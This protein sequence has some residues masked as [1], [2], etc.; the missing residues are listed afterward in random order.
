MASQNDIDVVLKR[1]KQKHAVDPIR[2]L[3]RLV[4]ELQRG[5]AIQPDEAFIL[6]FIRSHLIENDEI[7][8]N[9]L[10]RRG[11]EKG[12]DALY[13]DHAPRQVN[14]IQGKYR[15]QNVGKP[16]KIQ[17]VLQLAH[18]GPLLTGNGDGV[19]KWIESIDV[20]IK[21]KLKE[22]WRLIRHKEYGLNLYYV[23]TGSISRAILR[24]AEDTAQVNGQVK[25]VPI[26][27]REI[28]KII[29]DYIS[30]AAPGIPWLEL[31]I[32]GEA[33]L[34]RHDDKN[35]IDSYVFTMNGKNIGDLL[36]KTGRRLFARNIRGFLGRGSDVNRS[37]G[38]TLQKEPE[39][40]WYF[41]NGVTIICDDAQESGTAGHKRLRVK[42]PQVINGQQTSNMLSLYG[43]TGAELLVKV[44]AIPR[45]ESEDFGR[46]NDLVGEIVAATNWQNR[47]FPSD[48]KSN[49]PEQIRIERELRKLRILYIRKRIA[50]GEARAAAAIKPQ[51]VIRKDE[52]AQAI[53]AVEL[54]PYYVRAGKETLFEADIYRKIFPS[55]RDITE[56]LAACHLNSVCRYE[57]KGDNVKRRGRWLAA[58]FLWRELSAFISHRSVRRKFIFAAERYW[59]HTKEMNSLYS[60]ARHVLKAIRSFYF[61]ER[62]TKDGYMDEA[63]FFNS[64]RRHLQFETFF[65]SRS[66]TRRAAT[67]RQLRKF[68]DLLD[69]LE[70]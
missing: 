47:I 15:L 57:A 39:S 16:E 70:I 52:L 63:S 28:Q 55:G 13:I 25:F 53:A 49:D 6:W 21:E 27:G 48:L 37:I 24:N 8:R 11:N 54:D 50:K 14:L 67:R 44:I 45:E 20:S 29:D 36:K 64:R 2:E 3:N 43:N 58:H 30:D 12:V 41:N 23:T 66:N 4:G 5:E 60:A 56:Y 26:H 19:T 34:G 31:D 40:F 59:H 62:K 51:Y 18:Y 22:A 38:E 69:V 46:F 17:D 68:A 61:K 7:S 10:T 65:E 9:C 1:S 42:N 35:K 33:I 32:E